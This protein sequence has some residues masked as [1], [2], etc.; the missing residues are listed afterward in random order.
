MNE[1]LCRPLPAAP[2][3]QISAKLC[4]LHSRCCPMNNSLV[5]DSCIKSLSRVIFKLCPSKTQQA[6]WGGK[7]AAPSNQGRLNVQ[8]NC[9]QH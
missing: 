4:S 5:N 3:W 8:L 9:T 2:S 6:F 1:E 7:T